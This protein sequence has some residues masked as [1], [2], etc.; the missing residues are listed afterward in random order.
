MYQVHLSALDG[1]GLTKYQFS[2]RGQSCRMGSN[3]SLIT[4]QGGPCEVVILEYC[5]PESIL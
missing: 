5:A 3:D 1:R 4:Q 2:L